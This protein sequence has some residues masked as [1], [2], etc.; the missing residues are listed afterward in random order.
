[1]STIPNQTEPPAP[2]DPLAKLHRMSTTAGVASQQY[3]AVNT[4]AIIA[5]TLGV[6]SSAALIDKVMLFIPA[7]GIIVALMAWRQIH[8]SNGTETGTPLAILGLLLCA[9]IGGS[10]TA[11]SIADY[12]HIRQDERQMTAIIDQLGADIKAKRYEAAYQRFN[13]VFRQRVSLQTFTGHLE[14]YQRPNVNGP[15]KSMEWNG[16]TPIYETVKG[17]NESVAVMSVILRFENLDNGRF[18]FVFRN[19][20]NGWTLEDMP[21]VFSQK[22]QQ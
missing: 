10:V 1:M 22:G 19:A 7:V 9:L 20:G 11:R 21:D 18:T 12:N 13:I 3:V 14:Y 16:I 2:P 17:G 15:L 4:T 6:A 8:N 5:V